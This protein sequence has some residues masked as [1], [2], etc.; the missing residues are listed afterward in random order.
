MH[1]EL[2]TGGRGK[3]V[4]PILPG[5]SGVEAPHISLVLI[6]LVFSAVS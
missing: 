2:S 3:Q 6:L 1:T 5:S 4:G